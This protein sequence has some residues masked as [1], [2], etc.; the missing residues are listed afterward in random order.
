[1]VLF[2]RKLRLLLGLV[3]E[4]E[5]TGRKSVT[6]LARVINSNYQGAIRLLLHKSSKE[7]STWN[8]GSSVSCKSP[9]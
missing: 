5:P 9:G 4:A 1:M 8:P 3:Y 7:E 6:V 2:R